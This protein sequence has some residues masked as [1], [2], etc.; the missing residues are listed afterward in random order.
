MRY[1]PGLDIRL[2]ERRWRYAVN[3]PRLMPR[4]EAFCEMNAALDLTQ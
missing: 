2:A 4:R 1:V 3:L